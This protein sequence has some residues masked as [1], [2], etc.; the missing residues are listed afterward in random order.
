MYSHK[1]Y[2]VLLCLLSWVFSF[3]P[4]IL[5]VLTSVMKNCPLFVG[6]VLFLDESFLPSLDLWFKWLFAYQTV[7]GKCF[8]KCITK[9]G[10]SLSGSESSC[11]SRCVDRYIEATG[12]IGRALFS[13]QR[14]SF[15]LHHLCRKECAICQILDQQLYLVFTIPF[16]AIIKYFLCLESYYMYRNFFMQTWNI[17]ASYLLMLELVLISI[18]LFV[19]VAMHSFDAVIRTFAYGI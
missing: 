14:W 16:L 10:S 6:W 13:A 19:P 3:C 1:Q 5:F 4:S 9:P 15:R 7:T 18:W 17:L 2:L 11:V 8:E 12:I